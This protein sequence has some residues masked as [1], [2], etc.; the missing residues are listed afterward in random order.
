M[1]VLRAFLLPC[2][3]CKVELVFAEER[4]YVRTYTG[5]PSY[6]SEGEGCGILA[7]DRVFGLETTVSMRKKLDHNDAIIFN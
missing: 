7:V 4:A 2:L 3:G 5:R 1:V 6:F